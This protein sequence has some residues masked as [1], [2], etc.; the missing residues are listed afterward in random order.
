M[1]PDVATKQFS[2]IAHNNAKVKTLFETALSPQLA[3]FVTSKKIKPN[4]CTFFSSYMDI[5]QTLLNFIR[6]SRQGLW[7]LHLSSLEKLCS[8]FFSQN[9]Y[10]EVCSVCSRVHRKDACA[11]EF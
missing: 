1:V 4:V 8:L 6:A 3:A 9:R 7:L 11:A 5:I 10:V 2:N